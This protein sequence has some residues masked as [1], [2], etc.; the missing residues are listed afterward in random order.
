MMRRLTAVVV[1][2]LLAGYA[3]RPI[4]GQGFDLA[5]ALA[6]VLATGGVVDLRHLT[7]E[8]VVSDPLQIGSGQVPCPPIDDA[9]CPRGVTLLL[10][11]VQIRLVDDGQLRLGPSSAL[12][13]SGAGGYAT[14]IQLETDQDAVVIDGVNG[15]SWARI[16]DLDI[17]TTAKGDSASGKALIRI[18]NSSY[19]RVE[20]VSL[21]HSGTSQYGLLIEATTAQNSHIGSWYNRVAQLSVAYR[22]SRTPPYPYT[23][24]GVGLVGSPSVAAGHVGDV[25]YNYLQL[26]NVEQMGVGLLFSHAHHNSVVGGHLLGSTVNVYFDNSGHNSLFGI[27]GNQPRSGQQVMMSGVNNYFNSFYSPSFS[28]PHQLGPSVH[29]STTVIGNPEMNQSMPGIYRFTAP[30]V[31]P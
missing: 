8:I 31:V 14:M 12:V 20:N 26:Q 15:G 23:S 3:A 16:A 2:V 30:P 13:G 5:A 25:S 24:V 9:P 4:N 22:T 17:R 10:G 6:A 7:G 11:T 28:L 27:K 19:N 29:P 1:L 18:R 21:W